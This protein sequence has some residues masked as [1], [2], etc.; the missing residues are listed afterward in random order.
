MV[1]ANKKIHDAFSP[2]SKQ[3]LIWQVQPSL[4]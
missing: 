3:L 1:S 4:V 2:A